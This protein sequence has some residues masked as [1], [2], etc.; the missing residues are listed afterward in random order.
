[1]KPYRKEVMRRLINMDIELSEA[2][3]EIV[4]ELNNNYDLGLLSTYQ[5]CLPGSELEQLYDELF[6]E[7]QE[8]G[9]DLIYAIPDSDVVKDL[10]QLIAKHGWRAFAEGLYHLAAKKESLMRVSGLPCDGWSSVVKRFK[11]LRK[12]LQM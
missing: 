12:N 7:P 10:K 8:V 5:E 1:M 9:K 6:D 11:S 3:L 2:Y 4:K